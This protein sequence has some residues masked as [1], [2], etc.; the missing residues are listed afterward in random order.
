MEQIKEIEQ[1]GTGQNKTAQNKTAQY[2][3]RAEHVLYK[4]YNRFP[5][6]FDHGK[7]V[8]LY[9]TD[10]NEYLDFGA[11][12]AVMGLGYGC[13]ELDEAVKEQVDKLYH[14]SNLFYNAP[15]VEAG[16]K[17]LK[18]SG[19]D[20]VFFTNSGTEAIEGALKIAKRYAYDKGMAPDYEI[21][22]MKHSFHGRSLG[23]LSVTGNDHYQE[24]FAPLIP[25]IRFAEFND[26]ES[27]KSLFDEKT[28]AVLMETIQGEGG[29]YPAEDAFIQGVR[30]LCDDHDAL[31]IF[32]EIQC[33]MGRT[34]EM[35]AWQGYG[36][37]PD[38]MT[39]A[40]AL[41]NGVPIG[42][43]LACGKAASAM[44]PGDHGT[45]Y[46]GNPLVCA[47]ASKVLDLFE[48]KHITGH[49]KEIGSYLWEKLDRLPDKYDCITAHRGRGL[50]QGL[51]FDRPVAPVVT[52]ALL[53]Q[54]LVLISAGAQI[55]RF[56]PPLV[57]SRE[58]VDEM[59][60]RLEAAICAVTEVE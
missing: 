47:A 4:T 3:D 54:K 9:D 44:V 38:V 40:K 15:A 13:P 60:C 58:D 52:N 20:K 21:I 10:G 43:F 51:E 41:G 22:A 36:V 24:P 18:A 34:G 50:I 14:I 56:V 39:S 12:I 29:I 35:F 59:A 7:G 23:A 33:G 31:L 1:H 53:E 11:G 42:A 48:E 57:I 28:C 25:N 30:K 37:K 32:D 17:L 19:M 5:V 45:T 16:E 2:I 8:R 26:L 27:V 49:V 46:G 55:I 6:V